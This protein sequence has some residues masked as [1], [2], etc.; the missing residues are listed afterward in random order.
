MNRIFHYIVS[1]KTYFST[2]HT[3]HCLPSLPFIQLLQNVFHNHSFRLCPLRSM[4]HPNPIAHN[5]LIHR[6]GHSN[7][8]RLHNTHCP[9]NNYHTHSSSIHNDPHASPCH[10]NTNIHHYSTRK[11]NLI[12][13]R[14]NTAVCSSDSTICC[15]G[16]GSASG[17]SRL[18]HNTPNTRKRIH[19]R[20]HIHTFPCQY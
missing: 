20:G 11:P 17:H 3:I 14:R 12:D 1:H 18:Y 16:S 19:S 9:Y 8:P 15:A 5:L 10:R 7:L 6:R 2:L 13:R 4:P